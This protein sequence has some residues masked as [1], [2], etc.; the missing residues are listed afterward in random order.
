[1]TRYLTK[2]RFKIA[3]E[4][5][6]K[7]F[8]TGKP[9]VYPDKKG[10]DS[11]L[12]ALANGG[13]QVGELAKHYFP[14][15][16]EVNTSD[17]AQALLE[18]AK[19]LQKE[20]VVI[21]EAALQHGYLFIRV[22]ILVKKANVIHLLEVK[23]K[24]AAG[25]D[26]QQFVTGR[27]YIQS[28]WRTYLEDIAFQKNVIL[29]ALPDNHITAAL[30]L[31]D[32]QAQC[33]SQGLNQKFR[34]VA[35]ED[36]RLTIEVAQNVGAE[37]FGNLLT[38]IPVDHLIEQIYNGTSQ[39]SA[40]SVSFRDEIDF[41]AQSYEADRK[42]PTAIS[43]QCKSCE[44][45]VSNIELGQ[46]SG[47][48]ECWGERLSA[49][50]LS[51]P[52]VIDV[53]S[54]RNTGSLI[55][56]GRLLLTDVTEEDLNVRDDGGAGLSS[57]QRQNLQVRKCRENDDT[58]YID[59][60]GLQAEMSTW[61]FPLHFIDFE[62][63]TIAIPFHKDQRPYEQ[64]AFQFSHHTI[65]ADGQM[66]HA[67]EYL[68][69]IPGEFPNFDFVRALKTALEK[70]EGTIFRYAAHENTVLAQILQQLDESPS[71]PT[72]ADELK[73]FIRTITH[74]P[75][76]VRP[77]WRGDRD[78]VDLARIVKRYYYSP[79][80]GGSNSLKYVLPAILNNSSFLQDKYSQ[81][82]YGT[83]EIPSRNFTS[84]RWLDTNNE[85]TDPYNSL[86]PVFED[87]EAERYRKYM[88]DDD[89][90]QGG[91]ALSAYGYLQFTEMHQEERKRIEAALLRYCELD[92]L[93]M[94]MLYE[95]LSDEVQK[96]VA[97]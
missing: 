91:A 80:M 18:T 71:P 93:A 10:E 65:T 86:P 45:R 50:E 42:I 46:I 1:M 33:P 2:S 67:D 73:D 43:T 3:R 70:D 55:E 35:N 96:R 41:F 62:T 16:F 29:C 74:S 47:F 92:T 9:N 79:L 77:S 28:K 20:D 81:P 8:Y 36:H 58:P 39:A 13:Y 90:Q 22:D 53:W 11:F 64:I 40:P 37:D 89:I 34:V 24:S 84:R 56:Q 97:R 26:A 54:L 48:D 83:Q 88:L 63:S 57:S 52:L 66:A 59:V 85:K 94:V 17:N 82:I 7:L 76:A 21:Y 4:C 68:N 61:T 32:K 78:M 30:M 72:D 69:A 15:G 5:P 49:E 75:S 31:V 6:T 25:F 60:D 19:L 95:M 44:F 12:Q 38:E 51:Q 23:A 27:G 14:G 87:T